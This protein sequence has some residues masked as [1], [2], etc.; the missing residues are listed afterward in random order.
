MLFK[1][2]QALLI[3]ATILSATT[4]LALDCKTPRLAAYFGNGMFNSREQ[5]SAGTRTGIKQHISFEGLA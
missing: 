3:V 5:W 4:A 1:T 2:V